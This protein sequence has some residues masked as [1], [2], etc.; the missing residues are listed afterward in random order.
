MKLINRIYHYCGAGLL[1]A[2]SAM[3]ALNSCTEKIDESNLY[4]FTGEM[5]TDHFVNNPDAFSSYLY[6]LGK[7]HP[8][9]RSESTMQELLSARGNYTCFAPTNE[10]IQSYLDSLVTIGQLESNQLEQISDSVAEAIVFN[11][12]IENGDDE[13]YASTT[14]DA[15]L[16]KTNMNNRYID[17]S[18]ANDSNNNKLVYVNL[19]SRIIESD[20]EVENGYI[21]AIDKVLSPSNASVA[22]LVINCENTRLF[23]ELL[24]ITGWD[25]KLQDYE[26]KQ[27]EED[28]ED[29]RGTEYSGRFKTKYPEKRYNGYTIFVE[30]DSVFEANGITDVESLKAW[31]KENAYYNDD[32]SGNT[33]PSWGDDYTDEVNAINQFVS[34]HL[35]PEQLTFDKLVTFANEYGCDAATM[36]TRTPG[37][38]F[39]NVWEYW[40]TMGKYRRPV[41]V[42][43]MRGQK[44]LNRVSIYN[45]TTYKERTSLMTENLG[46]QVLPSNK[47]YVNN[48]RNGY[49]FP[50][51]G[52]LVWNRDVP[53][54]VLNERMRYDIT[55]L[56][57]EFQTNNIRQNRDS[58]AGCGQDGWILPPGYLT[59][60]VDM[61]K[62]T[63]F[64]YLPNVNYGGGI[65]SWMNYQIDE[66]NINGQFDFT[67]KLPPVPYTGTYE[68]RYG[69]NSNNNRGMAQVYIGTN[70]NNLPAIGIPLDLRE[71]SGCAA[72]ATGWVSDASLGSEDA[73]NENDKSMRNLGFMKGPKYIQLGGGNTGRDGTLCLRKVIY[74]GQLEAGKT[75]YI[76]FKS[77]L[78]GKNFEFFYDYLEMVPK[79]IY[80][81][82]VAEDRW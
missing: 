2:S 25:T 26:D 37:Q 7:V 11:S 36:K 78:A 62:E 27:W 60:V 54:K 35:L 66:F 52:I 16:G 76:R 72:S 67:M 50:V 49:Y 43:G 79:S 19:N 77:A 30:T 44:R 31:L 45:Q 5:M 32:T 80:A 29:I 65:G 21:H 1:A 82:D 47:T 15:T 34:Y 22:D 33:E 63:E 53:F 75:Y 39:V 46:I 41:K 10:A 28:N 23:G 17:I 8:S 59:N 58:K 71:S 24:T 9:K 40:E 57:P 55:S 73:I 18:F 38:F 42:T 3:V 51:D 13:A 12:I 68:I 4:T 74:T 56:F 81:G 70:P 48:A 64:V 69:I 20:I 61:T 14:F 6:I